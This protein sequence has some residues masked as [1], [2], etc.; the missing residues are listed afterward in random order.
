M[1]SPARSKNKKALTT[2]SNEKYGKLFESSEK[3]GKP[4]TEYGEFVEEIKGEKH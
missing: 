1:L 4:N 3:E 2:V